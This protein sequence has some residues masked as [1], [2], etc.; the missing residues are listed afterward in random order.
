MSIEVFEKA[1]TQS[2]YTVKNSTQGL[3]SLMTTFLFH[4]RPHSTCGNGAPAI[5][6]RLFSRLRR[7]PLFKHIT[8]R[9]SQTPNEFQFLASTAVIWT[10]PSAM[11]SPSPPPPLPVTERPPGVSPIGSSVR[12]KFKARDFYSNV[13]S[14]TS[15]NGT[16]A[17]WTYNSLGNTTAV[18][19]HDEGNGSYSVVSADL[20]VGGT[21]F[22]F[23]QRNGL[24]VPGS[25]FEVRRLLSRLRAWCV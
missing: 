7:V 21:T 14:E 13:I 17:S 19:V 15:G 6:T 22:L 12:A 1:A 24:G 10:N 25:P 4:P 16:F 3:K 20:R 5:Q 11:P 9:S 2:F 23:V 8:S 18:E